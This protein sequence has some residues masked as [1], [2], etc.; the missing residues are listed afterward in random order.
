[1]R[2]YPRETVVAEKFQAMV[3]L[4]MGNSRMKDFYDL[5]ILARRFAF[6]GATLAQA[7]QATFQRRHTD[8]PT[9][10]PL[11]LSAEFWGDR[12]K[13]SQWSAFLR[14]SSLDAEGTSLDQVILFLRDFLMP[15]AV[16]LA[17]GETFVREWPAGGPWKP[18]EEPVV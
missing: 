1:L 15:P 2:A 13:I 9:Q 12:T 3:M 11:A 6:T 17:A 4:G 18:S 8:L 10:A 16:A 7:I 5:W 14:K